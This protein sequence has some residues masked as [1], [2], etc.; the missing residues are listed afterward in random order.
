MTGPLAGDA[1]WAV[2]V[3]DAGV[4][5][6]LWDTDLEDHAFALLGATILRAARE[7]R[8][9]DADVYPLLV[10]YWFGRLPTVD[11][12]PDA[13]A[14]ARRCASVL[15]KRATCEMETW[16]YGPTSASLQAA[17]NGIAD[18]LRLTP[19]KL[20]AAL[21]D[22]WEHLANQEMPID[23]ICTLLEFAHHVLLEPVVGACALLWSTLESPPA[24]LAPEG[25]V[26]LGAWS[27][28]DTDGWG[29][30]VADE[31]DRLGKR[32]RRVPD[33]G[34]EAAA[35]LA[36]VRAAELGAGGDPAQIAASIVRT[37]GWPGD[38]H[39]VLPLACRAVDLA[40]EHLG[41]LDP[42]TDN[43]EIVDTIQSG[44]LPLDPIAWIRD[45]SFGSLRDH[46]RCSSTGTEM[47][48]TAAQWLTWSLAR[49]AADVFIAMHQLSA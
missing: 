42:D 21:A 22:H 8:L 48:H 10:R 27:P 33:D 17:R 15:A 44:L 9:S 16:M 31:L 35:L 23:G 7:S 46:S 45:P 20:L 41:A 34:D 28:V 1:G 11:W 37:S 25:A 39:L 26:S 12:P 40:R 3:A 6:E 19:T 2:R 43:D 49:A 18:E 24:G 36:R 13:P 4:P 5:L 32:A 38:T 47:F 29:A 30:V 14:L